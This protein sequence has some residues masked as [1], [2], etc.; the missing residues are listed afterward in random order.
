ME[1]FRTRTPKGD[2]NELHFDLL[3]RG[4]HHFRTRT[5]KG[6]GNTKEIERIREKEIQISEHE[7]RKG[8]ETVFH[9]FEALTT[10]PYFRTRTP[11]GDGNCSGAAPYSRDQSISEHEPRKG[12][13]TITKEANTSPLT[14]FRT[15]T[16]KGDGNFPARIQ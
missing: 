2:G 8:T 15:R 6:D 9:L 14:H 5:P 16:P 7:P 4:T 13:E 1:Y 3:G 10:S 11:K 12:T